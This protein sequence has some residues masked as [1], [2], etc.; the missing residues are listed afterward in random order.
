MVEII[1]TDDGRLK[2]KE[3]LEQI[4]PITKLI[5]PFGINDAW[6]INLFDKDI[7]K[8]TKGDSNNEH[9]KIAIGKNGAIFGSWNFSEGA[10]LF[11]HELIAICKKDSKEYN[12][13]NV[14]F[15][16]LWRRING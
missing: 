1:S 10:R 3:A 14:M 11:K 16:R 8:I 7:K 4:A 5:A 12:K 2:L 9:R 15:D 13:L 6:I